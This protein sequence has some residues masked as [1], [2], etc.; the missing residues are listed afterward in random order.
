MPTGLTN[1]LQNP[2]NVNI[3]AEYKSGLKPA[4]R[5][6]PVSEEMHPD[7]A[8]FALSCSDVEKTFKSLNQVF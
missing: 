1:I 5:S 6:K 4:T 3:Y 2:Y 7:P 8:N